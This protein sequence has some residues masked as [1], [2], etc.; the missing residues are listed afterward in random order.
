MQTMITIELDDET[1]AVLN[2]LAEHEHISLGQLLK[3]LTQAYHDKQQSNKKAQVELLTDFAGILS[4][5]P[6]FKGNPLEIQQA[7]R[8]EWS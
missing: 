4:D 8:D 7:M 5:S 2:K 3:N 1:A 6:S